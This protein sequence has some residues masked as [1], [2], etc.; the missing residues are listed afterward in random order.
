MADK[1]THEKKV[2]HIIVSYLVFS[3]INI[4]LSLLLLLTILQPG[5][6]LLWLYF[7]YAI[8]IVIS[9]I[10][11]F[12]LYCYYKTNINRNIFTSSRKV[13]IESVWYFIITCIVCYIYPNLWF[14]FIS[15]GI[16]QVYIYLR[17]L[18]QRIF[19]SKNKQF[20]QS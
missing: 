5:D 3:F 15:W 6:G 2:E 12:L 19:K 13:L 4:I 1:L 20:Q 9:P 8:I 10:N 16:V 11:T 17:Y 14:P 18:Y 7:F